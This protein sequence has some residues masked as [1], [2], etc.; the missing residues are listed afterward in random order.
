[1][2]E[3]ARAEVMDELELLALID[4]AITAKA[5]PKSSG[6]GKH[7]RKTTHKRVNSIQGISPGPNVLSRK[8]AVDEQLYNDE[9]RS[10]TRA[11]ASFVR[12][13][14]RHIGVGVR[15]WVSE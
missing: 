13:G 4:E 1:M 6:S 2:F 8:L 14:G 10:W 15:A 5:S 7:G 11:G 9:E 12:G 3:Q